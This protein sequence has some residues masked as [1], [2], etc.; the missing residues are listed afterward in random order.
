M[1]ENDH[2]KSLAT[3]YHNSPLGDLIPA[4]LLSKQLNFPADYRWQFIRQWKTASELSERW[5]N[6]RR[7]LQPSRLKISKAHS[8]RPYDFGLYDKKE[9]V[10][11]LDGSTLT[12]H[13]SAPPG[14][15][16]YPLWPG[17]W[18]E[19]GDTYTA[20]YDN[21]KWQKEKSKPKQEKK[22]EQ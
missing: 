12:I 21:A 2:L 8:G 15:V 1:E 16:F 10:Y 3:G 18:R 13:K 20:T 6:R 17:I 19:G 4:M 9:N 22:K 11:I 7:P 5:V 14:A